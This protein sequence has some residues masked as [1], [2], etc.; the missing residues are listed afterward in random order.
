MKRTLA[1]ISALCAIAAFTRPPVAVAQEK[2]SLVPL[3]VQVVVS[4]QAG[5]KKISNLPYT[6]WVTANDKTMT[7]VR[8]GVQVPVTQTLFG[9]KDGAPQSSYTYKDVGTNI[10]CRAT[11]LGDGRFT[12]EIRLSDSSLGMDPKES[13]AS[14]PSRPVFRNFSSSFNI[15]LRDGQTAQYAS[16]TDPVTGESLKVDVTLTVLK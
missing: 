7:S 3:R 5:E 14:T 9:G 16:A 6:L 1:F 2:S 4:R 12:L 13:A 10:D 11:A 8:M 15:L